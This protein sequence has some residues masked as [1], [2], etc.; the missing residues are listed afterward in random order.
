[1]NINLHVAVRTGSKVTANLDIATVS[2]ANA[3]EHW[4]KRQKR[5][6]QQRGLAAMMLAPWK[7][8]APCVVTMTRISSRLLDSDN[9]YGALKHV[10]D[11]VADALG[12]N[13]RDPRVTWKC[14]QRK[15]A[16]GQRAVQI[17]IVEEV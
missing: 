4:R 15:G 11:G 16:R 14:E 12:I 17:E 13:D 5:A 10:R 1:V 7:P 3:H 8:K 2:E 6:K 9:I